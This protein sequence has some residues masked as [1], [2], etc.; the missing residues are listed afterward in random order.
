MARIRIRR[1][2]RFRRRQL[3]GLDLVPARFFVEKDFFNV[4][5]QAVLLQRL[6]ESRVHHSPRTRDHLLSPPDRPEP[7]RPAQRLLLKST[8][9]GR[10][11][12]LQQV[13]RDL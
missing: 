6:R 10:T 2:S 3:T 13:D 1:E 4:E 12:S 11:A 9:H 5:T 8:P 7:E